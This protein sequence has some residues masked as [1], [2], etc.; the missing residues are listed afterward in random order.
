MFPREVEIILVGE[1]LAC[2]IGFIDI[3]HEEITVTIRTDKDR[4]DDDDEEHAYEDT[5]EMSHHEGL[6]ICLNHKWTVNGDILVDK[7]TEKGEWED[8]PGD[9]GVE[10]DEDLGEVPVD[11]IAVEEEDILTDVFEITQIWCKHTKG[12]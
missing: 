12:D 3:L 1:F 10:V 6:H 4:H 11:E 8:E 5:Y 9:I 7:Y 2:E